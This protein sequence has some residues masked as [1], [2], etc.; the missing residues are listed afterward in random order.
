MSRYFFARN[1][2]LSVLLF[3][4]FP[5]LA[6][7]GSDSNSNPVSN[8]DI[9]PS[10]ASTYVPQQTGIV[11]FNNSSLSTLTY[12]NCGGVCAFGIVRLTPNG[13]GNVSPEA[14][15]GVVAQFDSPENRYAQ[16]QRDL[17]KAQSARIAQ[18]DE[19]TLL[20]KFADAVEN[21]QDARANIL[22]LSA[23]KSLRMTPEQLLARAYKQ[24]R[25]CDSRFNPNSAP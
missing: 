10:S 23:A 5:Q 2:L 25:K 14:V 4:L 18:E 15:I 22:A 24:P 12:P 13:N 9:A 19:I 6:W 21:C 8:S 20:T 11:Q 3:W 16:A 1:L 17:S 7:A